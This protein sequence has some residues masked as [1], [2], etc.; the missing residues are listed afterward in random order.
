MSIFNRRRQDLVVCLEC[1]YETREDLGVCPNCSNAFHQNRLVS[2]RDLFLWGVSAL[3]LSLIPL[4]IAVHF[5]I[6]NGYYALRGHRGYHAVLFVFWLV[7][8][9]GLLWALSGR[10]LVSKIRIGET[11]NKIL[12]V[13]EIAAY[14]LPIF[15]YTYYSMHGLI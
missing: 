7:F 9:K 13:V 11:G 14:G 12:S 2:G 5:Y 15:L 1:G 3:V 4:A 6:D 8:V 10:L